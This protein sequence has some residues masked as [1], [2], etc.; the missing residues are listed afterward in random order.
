MRVKRSSARA[1]AAHGAAE[2]LGEQGEAAPRHFA[3]E[4]VAAA[5]MAVERRRRDAGEPR[6]LDQGEAAEPALG[7]EAPRRLDQRLLEVAVVVALPVGWAAVERSHASGVR[8]RPDPIPRRPGEPGVNPGPDWFGYLRALAKLGPPAHMATMIDHPTRD[9][10]FGVYV[11][12]PFCLAKCPYCDF[13]SHVRHAPVDQDALRRGFPARD[14]ACRGPDPRPHRH[15]HLP[16]RR[17]ALAHG[18]RRPSAPC[19]MPS[20]APGRAC[21]TSR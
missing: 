2:P 9:A 14:R 11:H 18:A 21:R 20:P 13:N 17:H 5:E 4:R 1:A 6:R 16:W 7:D 19:S 3:D 10:G 8:T 15:Q 12:W